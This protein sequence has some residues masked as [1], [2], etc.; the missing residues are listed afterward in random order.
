MKLFPQSVLV[1]AVSLVLLGCGVDDSG[2]VPPQ[3]EP[4][5][6]KPEEPQPEEPK[7]EE[8]KP[9]EPKPEEP[10]V[11]LPRPAVPQVAAQACDV[12]FEKWKSIKAKSEIINAITAYG[13]N[14][15]LTSI[16]ESLSSTG[17][18]SSSQN[19]SYVWGKSLS[20]PTIINYYVDGKL[21]STQYSHDIETKTN[22]LADDQ[23]LEKLKD[24]TMLDKKRTDI[25]ALL[26]CAGLY[27]YSLSD[28]SDN[29]V[30]YYVW[31]NKLDDKELQVVFDKDD[32]FLTYQITTVAAA[33]KTSSCH[34]NYS[35]WQS[36][37]R[38][39]ILSDAQTKLGGCEGINRG[40][41]EK[42]ESVKDWGKSDG[43]TD[44]V[45]LQLDKD[46]Y[47]T[48]KH[49]YAKDA[50]S[51]VPKDILSWQNTKLKSSYADVKQAMQCEGVLKESHTDIDVDFSNPKYVTSVYTWK[52][53]LLSDE[54]LDVFYTMYFAGDQLFNKTY[55]KPTFKTQCKPTHQDFNTLTL[56][57][58]WNVV[59]SSF[60][61]GAAE[62]IY[63]QESADAKVRQ[64][65]WGSVDSKN[66]NTYIYAFVDKNNKLVSK[67][68]QFSPA[69]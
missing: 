32:K 46:K 21:N 54:N 9:E 26:G 68:I 10:S 24:K 31:R 27:D 1:A 40:S 52:T 7:P 45:I 69:N 8:P 29:Y 20:K 23:T 22:C 6:P 38:R 64:Y 65:A 13:C 44:R 50:V 36:I 19:I 43:S 60:T 62:L 41:D 30:S 39:M 35:G 67:Y 49:F 42:D 51:C 56:N 47:V 34:P 48:A 28:G 4:E 33:P 55:S 12:S 17:T 66:V 37:T 57:S 18:D 5:K 61:C 58:S 3:P 11:P 16:D 15:M 2:Y 14:G 53:K 63:S 25:E 59:E